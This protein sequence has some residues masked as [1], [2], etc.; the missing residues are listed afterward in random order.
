MLFNL[1]SS[2]LEKRPAF[3][4]E[5]LGRKEEIMSII[6]FGNCNFNCPYCKRD[7]QFKDIDGNIIH[8]ISL[9]WQDLK[10]LID[11]ACQCGTRIRLSGGDPC[12]APQQ[13]LFIAQY[14]WHTYKQKISIAHNGSKPD[15]IKALLPYL[16]YAAIDIKG[17]ET[18]S[19]KRSG[20]PQNTSSKLLECSLATQ[21]FCSDNGVLVD[22]RTTIFKDT[23]EI[24]LQKIAQSIL[25]ANSA[26][27]DK[28]F[29]TI[30]KYSSIPSCSF[31]TMPVEQMINLCQNIKNKYPT[32][33][34]GMR[35]NW[36]N[37]GFKVFTSG[38]RKIGSF[39]I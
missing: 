3:F 27:I 30:R 4:L 11:K 37:S 22:V 12:T 5:S 20:M 29:W 2:T 13:S 38:E 7:G 36:I 8:S 26:N 39:Q 24:E 18:T 21:K 17:D 25:N 31:K 6:S 10:P 35:D 9:E 1:L 19:A 28:V 16:A 34:M 32:I 33:S 14:V 15:F 23:T